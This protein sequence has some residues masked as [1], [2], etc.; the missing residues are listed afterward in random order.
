MH[1]RA[2]GK[3]TRTRSSAGIRFSWRKATSTIGYTLFRTCPI[4]R[5]KSVHVRILNPKK[6]NTHWRSQ[7]GLQGYWQFLKMPAIASRSACVTQRL[8]FILTAV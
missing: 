8:Y 3:K 7:C 5:S 4:S 2:G 6:R 1:S